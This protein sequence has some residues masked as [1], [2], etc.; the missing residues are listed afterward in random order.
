MIR[1]KQIKN[2]IA[3]LGLVILVSPS[4]YAGVNDVIEWPVQSQDQPKHADAFTY[5]IDQTKGK[6]FFTCI[7]DIPFEQAVFTITTEQGEVLLTEEVEMINGQI[8]KVLSMD[9][10]KNSSIKISVSS[11]DYFYQEVIRF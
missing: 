3:A 1:K 5:K 7:A 11:E 6:I 10:F 2:W 4:L 9:K 8:F